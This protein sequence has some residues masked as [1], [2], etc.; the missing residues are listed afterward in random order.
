VRFIR[1]LVLGWGFVASLYTKDAQRHVPTSGNRTFAGNGRVVLRRDLV[2][3]EAIFLC[4][5][6]IHLLV[7]WHPFSFL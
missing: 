3:G 4:S 2:A 5:Q 1:T 7:D 6:G